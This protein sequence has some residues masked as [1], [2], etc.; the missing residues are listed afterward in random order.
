MSVTDANVV[1][2]SDGRLSHKPIFCHRAS[3]GNAQADV[4]QHAHNPG[5]N[6]EVVG[7]EVYATGVTAAASVDVKVGG[8]SVLSSAITPVAGSEVKGTVLTT[9]EQ[10]GAADD[11][12]TIHA[13]TDGG[14]DITNLDARVW[15]RRRARDK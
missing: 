1:E 10:F 6:Y 8:T 9:G 4:E 2:G 11:D 14:G 12:I 7:V 13:T 15:Y 3:V 5:Y